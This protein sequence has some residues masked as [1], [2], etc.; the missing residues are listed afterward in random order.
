[1]S[2]NFTINPCLS[3]HKKF[4]DGNYDVNN[5]NQCCYETL[6]AFQGTGS[7]N[8]VRRSEAAKNC[9]ECVNNAIKNSGKDPCDL[10]ISP[11][12]L[13]GNVPHFFPSLLNET[14]DVK[15]AGD[16]CKK[17]CLGTSYPN[18]CV[19]NCDTDMNAVEMYD[20]KEVG[21][22]TE[23]KVTYQKLSSSKYEKSNKMVYYIS[24]VIVI[25]LLLFLVWKMY[26]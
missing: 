7:V 18:Q 19:E 4:K 22:V 5:I 13:W 26:N 20:G 14:K 6:D 11:P 17:M 2:D 24:V 15:R 10:R 23:K 16:E 3:C 9:V 21:E 12:A 25:I 8:S 1:M